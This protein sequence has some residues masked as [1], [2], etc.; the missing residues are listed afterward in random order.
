VAPLGRV[1]CPDDEAGGEL[2]AFQWYPV[3]SFGGGVN[4]AADPMRIEDNQWTFSHAVMPDGDQA[5]TAPAFQVYL[6][7]AD[8]LTAGHTPAGWVPDLMIAGGGLLVFAYPTGGTTIDKVSQ[9]QYVWSGRYAVVSP[10]L[11]IQ[12][13]AVDVDV[14]G[15]MPQPMTTSAVAAQQLVVTGV[16]ASGPPNGAFKYIGD[17]YIYCIPGIYGHHACAAGGHGVIGDLKQSAPKNR[18]IKVSDGGPNP[19]D[20]WAPD[21]SNS[22]DTW[23]ADGGGP[24]VALAPVSGGFV[25]IMQRGLQVAQTTRQIPPFTVDRM[26][27]RGGLGEG[28]LTPAGLI[29]MTQGGLGDFSGNLLA[30]QIA[31]YLLANIDP[32]GAGTGVNVI[33]DP[34][35]DAVAVTNLSVNYVVCM[36]LRTSAVWLHRLPF[37]PTVPRNALHG[38]VQMQNAEVFI[39]S[40]IAA[41]AP[42]G[43][44]HTVMD[45]GTG[46]VWSQFDLNTPEADAYVDTKDFCFGVNP[47]D[48]PTWQSYVDRIKVEWEGTAV[49]V[50]VAVRNHLGARTAPYWQ[51]DATVPLT[52]TSLG[53]LAQGLSELPVRV[54]GKFFRFRFAMG[55]PVAPF[56]IR[57]FSIRYLPASDRRW[58]H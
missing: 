53:T 40:P 34:A 31:P 41:Q 2:M 57:G 5:V 54:R 48:P 19:L 1:A 42:R 12:N 29:Y 35:N 27:S 51:E 10:L 9:I 38:T 8:W 56:R 43:T 30:P 15:L 28:T 14:D 50:S 16:P 13:G 36:K 49:N 33:S 6:Q 23:Q 37:T 46:R 32:L 47:G 44:V 20:V 25:I 3:P 18:T 26:Q 7:P 11:G 17:G 52:W 45:A 39:N 21:I 22:A 55:T 58:D 24:I 4:V